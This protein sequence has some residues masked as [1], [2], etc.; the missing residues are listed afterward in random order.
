MAL[1]MERGG[2]EFFLPTAITS[3]PYMCILLAGPNCPRFWGNSTRTRVPTDAYVRVHHNP[4]LR[5]LYAD[6]SSKPRRHS[7]KYGPFWPLSAKGTFPKIGLAGPDS[8]ENRS[9][10]ASHGSN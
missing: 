5:P 9:S 2:E 8:V 7:L 3:K 10:K 1:D 4:P 6:H